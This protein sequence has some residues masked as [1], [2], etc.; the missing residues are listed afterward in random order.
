MAC[1]RNRAPLTQQE[2]DKLEQERIA[3]ILEQFPGFN[4]LEELYA[5]PTE[6]ERAAFLRLTSD[7]QGKTK[8]AGT[9]K[10]VANVARVGVKRTIG[11][12]AASL[13]AP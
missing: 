7:S 11:K 2:K 9:G 12:P 6:E 8:E 3:F 5:P 1:L 10:N 13:P 4:S